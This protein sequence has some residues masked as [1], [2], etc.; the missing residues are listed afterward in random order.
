MLLQDC[1]KRLIENPM[2]QRRV[3][4]NQRVLIE[5]M[6][7]GQL[8]HAK[9]MLYWCERYRACNHSLLRFNTAASLI[10]EGRQGPW[11]AVLKNLLGAYCD[12]FLTQ[13]RNKLNA[14]DRIAAQL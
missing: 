2:I 3:N 4:G 10:Y 6:R 1:L 13:L 7:R 8:L 14:D 9:P 5:L 12:A 11:S